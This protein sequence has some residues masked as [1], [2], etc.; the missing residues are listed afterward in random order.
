[1]HYKRNLKLHWLYNALQ[2]KLKIA[3]TPVEGTEEPEG[4]GFP[5]TWLSWVSADPW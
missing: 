5:N 3:L 4:G 1:M 2:K